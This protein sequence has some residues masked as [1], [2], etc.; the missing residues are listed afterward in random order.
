MHAGNL[1]QFIDLQRPQTTINE[2]GRPVTEWITIEEGVPAQKK[3]VSGREFYQA[4][5]YHAEDTVT[6]T[7]RW[8]DDIDVTCRVLYNGRAF[9][10]LE[11]NGLGEMYDYIQIKCKEIKGQ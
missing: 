5:A 3:D 4:L 11:I 9:N 2:A 8:R 1:R 6:F 10:I 7:L